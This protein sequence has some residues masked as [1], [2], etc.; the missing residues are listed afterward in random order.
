MARIAGINLPKPVQTEIKYMPFIPLSFLWK[1]DVETVYVYL[2]GHQGCT[3]HPDKFFT[4]I[5]M[6][7]N[8]P[9]YPGTTTAAPS[10]TKAVI[11]FYK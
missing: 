8:M 5:L 1:G 6:D 3:A 4:R 9:Y 2:S 7:I 11:S 10:G